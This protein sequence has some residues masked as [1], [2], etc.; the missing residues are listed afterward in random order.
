MI[1]MLTLN[2]LI[3]N[4]K[5]LLYCTSLQTKIDCTKDLSCFP[6]IEDLYGDEQK[7]LKLLLCG[8][9]NYLMSYLFL[10]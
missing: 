8:R 10:K 5:I 1:N 3:V 4:R 7:C 6:L 2:N 9:I